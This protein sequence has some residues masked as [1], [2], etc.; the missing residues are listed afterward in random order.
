MKKSLIPLLCVVLLGI[1]FFA[2][3][4]NSLD[5]GVKE[6]ALINCL[7]P[8]SDGVVE[9][10]YKVSEDVCDKV[11]TVVADAACLI[12]ESSSSESSSSTGLSSS[13]GGGGSSSS[14]SSG[15]SSSETDGGSSSSLQSSSSTIPS[16][17]SRIEKPDEMILSGNFYF[18]KFD[19]T[20]NGV[21]G[22]YITKGIY[23]SASDTNTA[24][25]PLHHSL[26]ITNATTLGCGS[27]GIEVDGGG[28]NFTIPFGSSIPGN[29]PSEI[30]T[31][32]AYA[33]ATCDGIKYTLKSTTAIIE[34]ENYIPPPEWSE[35]SIPKYVLTNEPIA[36]LKFI[37]VINDEEDDCSI[38]YLIGGSPATT[39]DI[40]A[41]TQSLSI[42]ASPSCNN[43]IDTTCT[44][45][46][47]AVSEIIIFE[48]ENDVDMSTGTT[49]IE[50]PDNANVFGC[51]GPEDQISFSID[52]IPADDVHNAWWTQISLDIQ[53][54]GNR[55]KFE[56]QEEGLRC[57][58]E[59]K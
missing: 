27:I 56:T 38:T 21:G 12:Y 42:T 16:S 1:V 25:A 23:A 17:S 45:N 33:V 18:R 5:L 9:R 58:A 59:R 13:S 6:P 49:Y 51:T 46:V 47:T 28:P 26:T 7:V 48:I 39:L 37:S 14:D 15:S 52:G 34:A 40:A 57:K 4:D 22:Y 41:G 35:C 19:F 50:V 43:L 44:K 54:N 11:G 55:I 24:A 8:E 3:S 2:C 36:D 10:C 30:G 53:N 32:T 29:N 20:T 31:I